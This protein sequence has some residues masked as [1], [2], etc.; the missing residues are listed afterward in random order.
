M[1]ED[2]Y[3]SVIAKKTALLFA[4]CGELGGLLAKGTHDQIAALREYGSNL[5]MAFQIRDDTL[6]WMGTSGEMGKPMATDLKQG[7][8]SLA[9]I[10]ARSK[11]S[12]DVW[13]SADSNQVSQMLQQMG[14]HD[15]ATV[16]ARDYSEKAKQAL[17][18]LAGSEVI[19]ELGKL[20]DLA[21]TR[22]R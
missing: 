10:Y 12:I 1:T 18:S 16:R 8:P 14:A 13:S 19:A 20:A 9:T 11:K 6:D 22:N 4:A 7:K 17:C 5:G 3:L 21:V 2:T 15:Y